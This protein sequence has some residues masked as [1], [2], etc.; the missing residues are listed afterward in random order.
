MHPLGVLVLV[1]FA[2]VEQM[3]YKLATDVRRRLIVL[4]VS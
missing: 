3:G 1:V 4:H 2:R